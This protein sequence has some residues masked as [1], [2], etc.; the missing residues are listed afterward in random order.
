MGILSPITQ[1]LE[2]PPIARRNQV[3]SS[4]PVEAKPTFDPPREIANA[5]SIAIDE[6]I[7]FGIVR[8]VLIRFNMT[9]FNIG[10]RSVYDARS[11]DPE[12]SKQSDRSRH[13]L[14]Q[15]YRGECWALIGAHSDGSARMKK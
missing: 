14:G 5:M 13:H 1:R 4:A 3:V 12:R 8:G 7:E 11:D 2:K 6:R 9:R 10:I 15:L